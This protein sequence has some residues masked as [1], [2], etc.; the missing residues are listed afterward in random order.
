MGDPKKEPTADQRAMAKELFGV[1]NALVL[2]GFTETQAC[3]M[4]GTM[5]GTAGKN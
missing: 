1:F 5:L 3:L 2:E 4:I